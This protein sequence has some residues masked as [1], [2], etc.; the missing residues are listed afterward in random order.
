[1]S[2]FR[3]MDPT[4]PPEELY[5]LNK[6]RE[7]DLR[8]REI[9][10]YWEIWKVLAGDNV[11]YSVNIEEMSKKIIV[12]LSWKKNFKAVVSWM[13]KHM[14]AFPETHNGFDVEFI[15]DEKGRWYKV[16]LCANGEKVDERINGVSYKIKSCSS[17]R[18]NKELVEKQLIK[19]F[20]NK[21][22][23]DF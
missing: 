7:R 3:K 19:N 4:V 9:K 21:N 12:S 11:D 8:E 13:R 10:Y 1:M 2:W 14:Q 17:F 6:M 20:E 16:K 22:G 15:D 23:K 5:D 18:G